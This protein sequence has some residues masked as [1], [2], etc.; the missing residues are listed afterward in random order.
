L[1]YPSVFVGYTF[2]DNV[3]ATKNNRIG[4]SGVQLAPSLEGGLDNGLWRTNVSFGA[5][6]IYYPGWGGQTR[7]SY[8]TGT[9]VNDAGP[10]NVTGHASVSETWLPLADWAVIASGNFI[11]TQ[12]LFGASSP[13]NGFGLGTPGVTAPAFTP[14]YIPT[15][16][17]FSAQQQYTNM[18]GGQ[19]SVQK[20]INERTSLS[21]SV[22]AQGVSYDSAPSVT[23]LVGGVPVN[24][25]NTAAPSG[26]SYGASLR[27]SFY[28][29][30]QI[31]VFV[32]PTVSLQRFD[33]SSANSNGYSA[34][35]GVGSNLI[36]L[37]QGEVYGGWQEQ[38]SVYGYFKPQSAP[39]FGASIRYLPTPILTLSLNFTQALGA[40]QSF[41]AG[42]APTTA[43]N[44]AAVGLTQQVYISADYGLNAYT[45]LSLRGGWGQT[46]NNGGSNFAGSGLPGLGL[47][48]LGFPGSGYS[49]EIWSVGASLSYNFWRNT[50]INLG[51]SY[52]KTSNGGGGVSAL[53]PNSNLLLGYTQNTFT[54]GIRYSY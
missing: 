50:S 53:L 44:N 12:G 21:G 23:Q 52:Q 32:Q 20:T 29:T 26:M 5:S 14:S 38:T 13:T 24:A 11:R 43:F 47:P 6:G 46:R 16:G 9:S 42:S 22:F 31:Y 39:S 4:A 15:I 8:F 41:G 36:G 3:Y 27:G 7:T 2:N 33:N 49:T 34:N 45:N 18:Y 51:Y 25:A 54:A 17:T 35:V 10:S 37:F 1:L 19:L 48:G 30:P 40:T 28:A